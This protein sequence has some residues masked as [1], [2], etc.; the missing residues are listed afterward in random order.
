[1][2]SVASSA[3]FKSEP[4]GKQARRDG[5]T[6]S[7]SPVRTSILVAALIQSVAEAARLA[8]KM[9][10]CSA[11]VP[12]KRKG[13]IVCGGPLCS[14]SKLRREQTCN[15]GAAL[16]PALRHS[17]AP[18]SPHELVASPGWQVLDHPLEMRTG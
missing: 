10:P 8:F 16:C 11:V 4:K 3:A 14:F 12:P 7:A 13:T 18:H 1:M 6:M 9:Q 15:R 17:D 2:R 5:A